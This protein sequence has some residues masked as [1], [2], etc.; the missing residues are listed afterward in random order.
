MAT[1]HYNKSRKPK[2]EPIEMQLITAVL[3]GLLWIVLL[4]F[5]GLGSSGAKKARRG[6]VVN[7]HEVVKQWSDIQ[8]TVGLGGT[9]HFAQGVVSAD[10]LLD[11]VLKQMGYAGDTMGERLKSAVDDMSPAIYHNVWQAHKLRN[12][13]V[14]EVGSEVMSFQVKEAI[15]QYEQALRDLGALR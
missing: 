14:H 3:R 1:N 5:K 6:G 9:S 13:L 10:K 11:H 15:G 4:P 8:T 2:S 7:T 12:Q